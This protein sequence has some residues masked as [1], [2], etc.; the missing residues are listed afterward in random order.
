M[1]IGKRSILIAIL[2]GAWM[3]TCACSCDDGLRKV[4]LKESQATATTAPRS[5]TASTQLLATQPAQQALQPTHTTTREATIA[6]PKMVPSTQTA[7]PLQVKPTL[8]VPTAPPV[9]SVQGFTLPSTANTPFELEATQQEINDYLAGE[10]FDQQGLAVRD[11]QVTITASELICTLTGTHHE[12]G[13][14]MGIAVRGVPTIVA[15]DLYMDVQD[16][17]LDDS[18]KGLV[19]IFAQAAIE[20]AIKQNSD[21]H[22]IL[23]PI[24]DVAFESISLAPGVISVTG[25][26]R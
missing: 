2:L 7:T 19:R 22:G 1:S 4:I 21:A 3:A 24:E 25:R 8:L 26:T 12:T 5:A 16:V 11:V 20:E 18:V 9:A 14:T 17:A 13:I 23:V 10:A 15:G 6:S